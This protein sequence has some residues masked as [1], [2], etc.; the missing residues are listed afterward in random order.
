[1]K[2]GQA[3]QAAGND[4]AV[5]KSKK[6]DMGFKVLKM[7]ARGF[8]GRNGNTRNQSRYHLQGITGT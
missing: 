7:T 8:W 2:T 3:I 5:E 4:G 6:G 1:L